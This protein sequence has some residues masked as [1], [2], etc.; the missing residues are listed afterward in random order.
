MLTFDK[1]DGSISGV[2]ILR[3]I[4]FTIEP[5]ETVAMIGRNGAGKTTTLRSVMALPTCAAASHST[6]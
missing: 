2:Q 5:A 6:T 4:S 1:V 3:N